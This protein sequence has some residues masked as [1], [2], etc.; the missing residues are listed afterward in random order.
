MARPAVAILS[1]PWDPAPWAAAVKALA[2][3]RP[4]SI[5]PGVTDKASIAYA[6]AWR[7]P[8]GALRAL[9]NLGVIFS[10]GA[11]VEH[12]MEQADRPAVP[13]VR[14]VN[15]DL[16]ARM[17]EWVVLQV[18]MQ[19]RRQRTYDRFQRER[20]WRELPQPAARDVR[21]GVM[22]MGVLG[23]SAATALARLGFRV[24]GWSRRGSTV[25]GVDSYAGPAELGRFLARTDILVSLLPLTPETRGILAMPLFRS[26]AR[27]GGLGKPIVINAGRGG[28]QVESDI[29]QALEMGILGG[30]SL[31]VFE[32]EPLPPQSPLWGREDV[33]V[34]PHAAAFSSPEELVPEMLRQMDSFEAGQPLVNVVDASAGY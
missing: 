13:V 10:L 16:T 29:V 26:L 2:P 30:A 19:H 6:L 5:W 28:L 27:D 1:G 25:S 31:D 11:G 3:D 15:D 34:T 23:R 12:L 8:A 21:V 20:L 9:P 24:A 14:V 32:T 4:V 33:I 7:P 17:T 22:G 18:L